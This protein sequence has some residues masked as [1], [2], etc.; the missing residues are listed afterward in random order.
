[1]ARLDTHKAVTAIQDAGADESLAAAI[2]GAVVAIAGIAI[3]IV[4]LG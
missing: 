1:M 3:A 4:E 2:V